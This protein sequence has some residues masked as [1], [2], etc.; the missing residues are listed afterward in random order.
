[1]RRTVDDGISQERDVDIGARNLDL[2]HVRET[3]SL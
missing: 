2:R 3:T 1:M